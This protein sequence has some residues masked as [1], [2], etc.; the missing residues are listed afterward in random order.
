MS[1][2]TRRDTT[3]S[4]EEAEEEQNFFRAEQTK[5]NEYLKSTYHNVVT[6]SLPLETHL[7][8]DR[9]VFSGGIPSTDRKEIFH[10]SFLF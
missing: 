1:V 8:H 4:D 7:G 10:L 3:I 2:H 6:P 5:C 9:D